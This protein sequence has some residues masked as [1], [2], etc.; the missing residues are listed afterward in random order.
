ML[1]D[2]KAKMNTMRKHIETIKISQMQLVEV[3][4]I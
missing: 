1:K 2:L 3:K 4:N